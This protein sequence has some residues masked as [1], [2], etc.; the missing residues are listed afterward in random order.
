MMLT[1]RY[2]D[3][4]IGGRS[5]DVFIGARRCSL[6]REP[7]PASVTGAWTPPAWRDGPGHRRYRQYAPSVYWPR[8]VGAGVST[9]GV[10]SR[11]DPRLRSPSCRRRDDRPRQGVHDMHR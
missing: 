11:R 1:G 2:R 7:G 4:I 9:G 5:I 10:L 6:T 8:V 3:A